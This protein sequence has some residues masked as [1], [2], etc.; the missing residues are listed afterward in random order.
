MNETERIT[1][2]KLKAI[3]EDS[4]EVVLTKNLNGLITSWS[5]AAERLLGYQA[6]EMIGQSVTRIIPPERQQEEPLILERLLQGESIVEYETVRVTK[7]GRR[8]D[9]LMTISPLRGSAGQIVGASSVFRDITE[10][11]QGQ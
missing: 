9:V 4:D 8:L 3:V 5:A 11:Q 6:Q 7:N 10:L 2:A 1:R